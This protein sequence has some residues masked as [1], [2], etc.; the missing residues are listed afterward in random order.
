MEQQRKRQKKLNLDYCDVYY[1]VGDVMI[2]LCVRNTIY[3]HQLTLKL[4]ANADNLAFSAPNIRLV[5]F[6][7][8]SP[9]KEDK[10][11]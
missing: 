4:K 8:N 2:I 11:A 5:I 7:F 3:V 10:S 1:I 6:C 9:F